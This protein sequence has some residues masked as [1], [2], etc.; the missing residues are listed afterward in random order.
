MQLQ[1]KN[2]ITFS[3]YA[4]LIFAL[5]LRFYN[6]K[7]HDDI[8]VLIKLPLFEK[9]LPAY[10]YFCYLIAICYVVYTSGALC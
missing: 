10:W 1:I 5:L 2:T 6:E 8:D 3:V 4:S 7:F 9:Q